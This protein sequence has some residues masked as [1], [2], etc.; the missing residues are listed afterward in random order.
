MVAKLT[1]AFLRALEEGARAPLWEG[2]WV[3]LC[4]GPFWGKDLPLDRDGPLRI[5][6]VDGGMAYRSLLPTPP[7]LW[8]GD[9]DSTKAELCEKNEDIPRQVFPQDKD[10]IDGELALL[11]AIRRGAR[12]IV[13]VGGCG[14]RTDQ[15]LAKAMMACGLAHHGVEV[16][17]TSGEEEIYPAIAR[18]VTYAFADGTRLSLV[19]L[20]PLL[21]VTLEGVRWPLYGADLFPTTSLSLSNRVCGNKIALSIAE[22]CGILVAGHLG[23]EE[24]RGDGKRA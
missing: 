8:M 1:S 21:G 12:R 14:G 11:E 5:I 6:A 23:F 4:A 2:T 13:V 20:T 19:P 17:L 10:W 15:T 7:L 16:I 3:L 18:R 22:G 24:R 9:F